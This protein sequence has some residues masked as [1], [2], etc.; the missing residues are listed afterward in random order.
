MSEPI[1]MAYSRAEMISLA[2]D[3]MVTYYGTAGNSKD[4]N[5]WC[6][7]F[8]LLVSFI[9]EHFPEEKP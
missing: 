2:K 6:E 5:R 8:G 1:K 3:Y 4:E 9:M 7:R